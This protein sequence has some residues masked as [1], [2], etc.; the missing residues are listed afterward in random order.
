MLM[1]NSKVSA[2]TGRRILSVFLAVL[3]V[4]STFM[5]TGM[6]VFATDRDSAAADDDSSYTVTI[7]DTENGTVSFS[8]TNKASKD[9]DVGD[10]VRVSVL[11]DDG[12]ETD[13][14]TA[15]YE[16]SGI[17]YQMSVANGTVVFEMPEEN[18]A[19]S[20]IFKESTEDGGILGVDAPAAVEDE[21]KVISVEDYILQN[22]DSDLVG[23]GD[24]LI[25]SDIITVANT[26]ADRSQ[27]PEDSLT[28]NTLW[29]TD[30]DG[31]GV[32]DYIDA[33]MDVSYSY[34]MLYEISANSDYYVG[35]VDSMSS[36]NMQL[37]YWEAGRNDISGTVYDDVIFDEETG[38]V[39]VPKT[40][41]EPT[42]E[43]GYVL[44]S[45]RIQLLYTVADFSVN[46]TT[47]VQVDI[48]SSG[49]KGDVLSSGIM[50]AS[51]YADTFSVQLANDE[52]S[53]KSIKDSTIDSI[54]V[55]DTE[56][57]SDAYSYDKETG[58]LTVNYSASGID[59][60]TVNLSNSVSKTVNGCLNN[61]LDMFTITAYADNNYRVDKDGLTNY[62]N[63]SST[64]YVFSS[65]PTADTNDSRNSFSFT[66]KA[67]VVY[68]FQGEA[69]YTHPA[70]HDLSD[71]SLG[72]LAIRIY[73]GFDT[74]FS[75]GHG[76]GI[77][78]TDVL[79]NLGWE[80]FTGTTGVTSYAEISSQ[81]VS[82]VDPVTGERITVNIPAQ[83]V[84]LLCCHLSMA[85]DSTPSSI[86]VNGA[87]IRVLKIYWDDSSHTTGTMIFGIT[88]STQSTQTG[89]GVFRAYIEVEPQT[90]EVEI[91]KRSANSGYTNGNSSG[92]GNLTSA[93]F[94][95]T[96]PVEGD[97][98]SHRMT[99]DSGTRSWHCEDLPA[100]TYLLTETSVPTGFNTFSSSGVT[101]K[102][103]PGKT[104]SY[105]VTDPVQTL[106]FNLEKVTQNG[107]DC[108]VD[109]NSNYSL[110][111]ARFTLIQQGATTIHR[112]VLITDKNG[113]AEPYIMNNDGTPGA[114]ASSIPR[115]TYVLTETVA[116]E[117]YDF[118]PELKAGVTLRLNGSTAANLTYSNGMYT[119][120][121]EDPPLYDPVGVLLEKED[122]DFKKEASGDGSLAGAEFEVRIFENTGLTD[123]QIV[124][125]DYDGE[126]I[127]KFTVVTD[128]YGYGLADR[129]HITD[130]WAENGH[131]LSEWLTSEGDFRFPFGTYNVRE[132]DPPDGYLDD[133]VNMSPMNENSYNYITFSNNSY[134]VNFS[135]DI[136][137]QYGDIGHLLTA[138][139]R[140][141]VVE[142]TTVKGGLAIRKADN[143][144]HESWGQGDAE[145]AAT[146]NIY[147]AS[148][149]SIMY[150]EGDDRREIAVGGYIATIVANE[151]NDYIA[152][153][154]G[155]PYGSYRIVEVAT[156]DDYNLTDYDYVLAIHPSE[157]EDGK[158][159]ELT[160]ED[161]A[162]NPVKR[163]GVSVTKFTEDL[164]EAF[165]EGDASL[166]GAELTIY[167]QSANPV[168]DLEGNRYEVGDAVVTIKTDSDGY[169]T[170]GANYLPIG[171]YLIRETKSS[172]GYNL[173]TVWEK[174]FKITEE[175][176]VVNYGTIPASSS[177][178]DFSINDSSDTQALNEAVIRG[179]I[180]IYKSDADRIT[181]VPSGDEDQPQGDASLANAHFI[182]INRSANKVVVN[183]QVFQPGQI[184]MT[185]HT[186]EEGI[187]ETA[188]NA[189][190]YG[191]YEIKEAGKE[192]SAS[193]P[194]GYYVDAGWSA[195]VYIRNEGEI[196]DVNS[197]TVN[198]VE[199]QVYRG[200]F[201]FLKIDAERNEAIP[202]GDA[203]LE[204]ALFYVTN[205][206]AS[207]VYVNGRWYAP[208][209]VCFTFKTDA[210]GGYESAKDAL[211]YGSYRITEAAPSTG[212][213]LNTDYYL[214]FQIREDGKIYDLT[215][216][217]CGEDVI[218]GDVQIIKNDIELGKSEAIGGKD[219]GNN[220]YGTDL[221][222][223]ELAIVN[224]SAELVIVDGVR[225]EPG[226]VCKTIVTHWN[227]DMQAYT[228]ETTGRALP[229]G[230]Y[231]IYEV[232]SVLS[233]DNDDLANEYY[234]RSEAVLT[235]Q[236]REDG[237]TVT[238]DTDG[239]DLIF[240]DQVVRGDIEFRKIADSTSA[241]MN[242]AWVLT[243]NTTGERHVIIAD[244]NGE[245]YSSADRVK[246]T[247][248]T[249]C[250]DVFFD[251]IDA[252]ERISMSEFTQ[253]NRQ[254]VWF[255]LGED[256]T[257]AK[258]NDSVCALPYGQ[259]TLSEVPTDTNEGYNLQEFVFYI[260]ENNQVVDIG[261]ITND[262]IEIYTELTDSA[263]GIHVAYA[264]EETLLKDNVEYE[265]LTSGKEYTMSGRLVDSETGAVIATAS[266]DF[267]ARPRGSVEVSYIFDARDYAGRNVVAYE[268]VIDKS[269]GYKVAEHADITDTEQTVS[270][271]VITTSAVSA[272]TNDHDSPAV[273]NV[274]VTD[275]VSY[276]NL[277]ANERYT[278]TGTLI[279][280]TTGDE[281][282]DANG[283]E[284]TATVEF[285]ARESSGTVDVEFTFDASAF[286]G[287]TVV[288]FEQ[289]EYK[290]NVVAAHQDV[291]DAEQTI[292][293]PAISTSAVFEATGIKE[294]A[295]M[296]N[297]VITD[298]VSYNNLIVGKEYTISGVLMDKDTGEAVA[299]AEG[300]AVTAEK[301]FVAQTADGS[302]D[303]DFNFDSTDMAGKTVVVYETLVR[304]DIEMAVHQDINDAA[305]TVYFPWIAT[306]ANYMDSDI[307]EA[308][309][310]EDAVITDHVEYRL[311]QAGSEY[312]MTGTL[313]DK[314]TGSAIVDADG[315]AITAQ[316]TFTPES[317]N[318]MVDVVFEFDASLLKG[319]TVVAYESLYH[320]DIEVANHNDIDDAAQSIYFPSIS[321]V[322]S[323]KE[324]G[325]DEV[326]SGGEYTLVDR[327]DYVNLIAGNE[328]VIT[329][330]LVDKATGDMLVDGIETTFTPETT[331]GT[332]SVE[333]PFNADDMAG[334][335]VVAYQTISRD[336]IVIAID[337]D[338]NNFNE[339]I[340][341]PK[342]STSA[343]S[344][345]TGDNEGI[346]ENGYRLV[347]TV[348]YENL[349]PG[350]SYMLTGTVV[351][352]ETG[353]VL[354]E[355]N[356]NPVVAT[357]GF[358]PEEANGTVE[359]EFVFDASQLGGKDVV[360][361]ETLT[362]EDVVLAEH[363]DIND[364]S[365]TIHFPSISTQAFYGDTTINEGQATDKIVI[366]D[367]VS[368]DNLREGEEYTVTGML[369]DKTTGEGVKITT[370]TEDSEESVPVTS[371]V[372]F[373]PDESSGQV[374]VTFEFDGTAYAG[375][376]LVVYESLSRND[377]E[378]T[379]HADLYD[380]VQSIYLPTIDTSLVDKDTNLNEVLADE[381]V[382]LVDTVNYHN[383]VV[384]NTYTVNGIL[385]DKS[386]GEP[387]EDSDGNKITATT[388]FTPET[389]DGSVELE[390]VFDAS[391]FAGKTFVAFEEV[392][393]EGFTV[394]VHQDI[395]DVAQTV[396]FPTI[397]T[398][399]VD[400]TTGTH[401]LSDADSVT[402]VDTVS[403]DN[404]QV[405]EEYT[406]TGTL[407]D[408]ETG[409]AVEIEKDVP[410]TSSVVFT[411]EETS[412]TVNV[413]FT[414]ANDE[415]AG[416]TF[417]VF[418]SLSSGET[419]VAQHNDIDD[420]SQTV[421]MMSVSTLATGSDGRSKSIDISNKAVIIDTVTYENLVPNV[422]YTILGS[423]ID[424]E[425]GN[426]A[427]TA[428]G[429]D[430]VVTATFTP[431]ESDGS[432]N[433][434][435]TVDTSE[436]NGKTLVVY[437][438][439]Y[440]NDV[441][442]GSHQDIDDEDQSVTVKTMTKLQTG[443]SNIAGIFAIIAIVV[444]LAAV[445]FL[446]YRK[447]MANKRLMDK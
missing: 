80:L 50:S 261:T 42:G 32:S 64:R 280:K 304:N 276:S 157:D 25:P 153:L 364:E 147:N 148:T 226:E 174:Q 33:F 238:A 156:S 299:D 182:V 201:K 247:T 28:L 252:G 72:N 355:S 155:L 3:M 133:I 163:G 87:L 78:N 376:T 218:R 101:L 264:Q 55:N 239:N 11:P 370:V 300:N 123:S 149:N 115:G 237:Q 205:T 377:V 95:V 338:I 243:N 375:H 103:N 273:N 71:E 29:L 222:G 144:S 328:Y 388:E 227:E 329:S 345:E 229:Y 137:N 52:K 225:Y 393:R 404:L 79:T 414:L 135:E 269:T 114:K 398:N 39:Y 346:T 241:R 140:P 274:T 41:R 187:A 97:S 213:L 240:E 81:T 170:T 443:I 204:G 191:T 402:I 90:G 381:D 279:N 315:N 57:S 175:G 307:H 185:L 386:T 437:E 209:E 282:F 438:T 318:G 122:P 358:T 118:N 303:V 107:D 392:T 427:K 129:D 301:T 189:L 383:L 23:S 8:D 15:S 197:Y 21:S 60:L 330:Q 416:K 217:P 444:L 190:P 378:R 342:I 435:F 65:E 295:P 22:A 207:D 372:E 258:P 208:G 131:P 30:N 262:P 311:L 371:E 382:T 152:T 43:G 139:N 83:N 424:K 13:T 436:A 82:A 18:V 49:V 146:F 178:V 120:T 359:V 387:A 134:T 47:D 249:N 313:Y 141:L 172:L 1:R 220:E 194:L 76:Y 27:L 100:G 265:G 202:Q 361:Y 321:T 337:N 166:E 334:K 127:I 445:A 160:E 418:E 347:D 316:T 246:H 421:H 74:G 289:L 284:I 86:N 198:P 396:Y 340:T 20:V 409:K 365:Q 440:D 297:A 397:A 173:N 121:A 138:E 61:L 56:I 186:N 394:A 75:D 430:A 35:K 268:S 40:Y 433:V 344:S 219:H 116:P 5:T 389:N 278:V 184:C 17:D 432:V 395:N 317:A 177:N 403:Y 88:S 413:E 161:F 332:F 119:Y 362:R 254:G 234:L 319:H 228:A 257:M 130:F 357:K 341:V 272:S 434:E 379:Y 242:T 374:T 405:G 248:N 235:F 417:V 210:K 331:D 335:S 132:I 37:S 51:I 112:Y 354:V 62:T 199:E 200:G 98:S 400:K 309:A 380:E 73:R 44:D 439:I 77:T 104:T 24:S 244:Q 96:G 275:T 195:T 168:Y 305:Q 232:S 215:G 12:Y 223:I 231:D 85:T 230:T 428:D 206:S 92:Y 412:G 105:T 251:R 179:G 266:V 58:V 429:K 221:N 366:N 106:Q 180:R 308:L 109:G 94:T 442:I 336:G 108:L 294:G 283:K 126:E 270:F 343:A 260:Y 212:Y 369:I 410:L 259:Y 333:I 290:G 224:R 426:A 211:P 408:K 53:L 411:P 352:K 285:I 267:T 136:L 84:N 171:T 326:M 48:V 407:M 188:A 324:T 422:E 431:K 89:S 67:N 351:D 203:T 287:Q 183:G 14:V 193:D 360:V 277:I 93:V 253:R 441:Q 16:T 401:M 142:T 233:T 26:V 46:A 419:V 363:A 327:I 68:E 150:G 151:A 113:H 263:T 423:V 124:S 176:M 339:T 353:E 54:L 384:G 154:T 59:V 385:M 91:I 255:G 250:N 312:V 323:E 145:L 36:D 181:T 143:Q 367:V 196:V 192:T 102:V 399:A 162:E 349:V 348:T 70:A 425:T 69:N 310:S 6:S 19:L 45:V 31:D 373:T 302:I 286:A 111:N 4:L 314:D 292:Y 164:F 288:V 291:D 390:F 325:L 66:A 256:G 446:I 245:F 34:Q 406:L 281:V 158:I 165:P 447:H 10:T 293:I 110:A 125:G 356:S 236:I 322:I 99:Y 368:Y 214:D 415:F 216:T 38:L 63:T 169:A 298:T 128:E 7:A 296:A 2:N 320:N 350:R 159:Y 306:T 391:S 9:F 117:G 420:E 167:N 271:P